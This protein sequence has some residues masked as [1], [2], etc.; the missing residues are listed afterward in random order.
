MDYDY[1]FKFLVLGN[2][3]VGKTSFL[4]QFI[5]GTFSNRFITTVGVDFRYQLEAR[6]KP[7]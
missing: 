2:S 3:G 1:L 7:V 4:Y 5:D 6:N